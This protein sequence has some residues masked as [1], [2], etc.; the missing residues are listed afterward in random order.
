MLSPTGMRF[1]S[2]DASSSRI[3]ITSETNAERMR[4]ADN[5]DDGKRSGDYEDNTQR[6]RSAMDA[7]K[8][9]AYYHGV[10]LRANI[11]GQLIWQYQTYD[12]QKDCFV[13][14]NYGTNK[15]LN[16]MLKVRPNP[17][18]SAFVM[19]QNLELDVIQQGNGLLYLE[20][21]RIDNTLQN[22]WLCTYGG[23]NQLDDTYTITYNGVGGPHSLTNVPSSD[24]I[25]IRNTFSLDNG[26]TGIST[27][28]FMRTS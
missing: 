26:L 19:M 9:S 17:I 5:E 15:Q 3:G 10:E 22:I 24:V 20:Y 16:Y 8:I 21:N 25:H 28:Q 13:E 14:N 6:I 1:R 27:L 23:Y 11:M 4:K 18:M 2:E 12:R 7:L